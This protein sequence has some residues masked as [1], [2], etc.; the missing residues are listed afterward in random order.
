MTSHLA[1]ISPLWDPLLKAASPAD[2]LSGLSEV[3][4]LCFTA[5][6]FACHGKVNIM[7]TFLFIRFSTEDF[8]PS[9]P[10]KKPKPSI[11][12]RNSSDWLGLKTNDDQTFL[13]GDDAKETKT[14]TESPKTPSSPSLERKPSLTGSQATPAAKVAADTPALS[15]NISKPTKPE[16]SKSQ[17][18]EEEE[19]DDWLA[20]ALSR[21]KALSVSKT[22][23]QE[24][25][26]GL[27]ED[28]D[29][30]STVRYTTKG[31]ATHTMTEEA[32]FSALNDTL[33]LFAVNTSLHKLPETER[34]L[35]HLSRKLGEIFV[36]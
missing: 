26:L 15:D 9:T 10:E 14:S 18:R 21:K 36:M 19:E 29:L 4:S 13:E 17:Q 1:P 33:L 25:S 11:R 22:S 12:H 27:G 7:W 30:E 5:A 20:G 28:V 16:V 8:S 23:K 3:Q 2:S 32:C 6:V 31:N 34:T 24:A 35:L